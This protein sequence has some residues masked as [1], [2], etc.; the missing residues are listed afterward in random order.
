MAL[1]WTLL[2]PTGFQGVYNTMPKAKVSQLDSKKNSKH[3]I[4][5]HDQSL[6]KNP[7][8]A[9]RVPKHLQ[10]YTETKASQPGSKKNSKF[11]IGFYG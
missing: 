4:N 7:I 6:Q 1:K 10:N 2:V 9:E 5:S 11:S 3:S 8:G